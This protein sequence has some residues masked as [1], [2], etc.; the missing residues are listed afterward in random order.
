MKTLLFLSCTLSFYLGNAQNINFIDALLKGALIDSPEVS[1]S[2]GFVDLNG[3]IITNVDT[4]SDGEISISEAQNIE[5]IDFY[6][7]P[8]TDLEGLQFFTNVKKITSYNSFATTFNFPSLINLEELV[9][10]G[11]Y[12][13]QTLLSFNVS[14]NISL[15]IL[16]LNIGLASTVDLSNNI[17][18][19][20]LRIRDNDS[21]NTVINLD[22]LS[23]LRKLTYF[24]NLPTLDISDCNKLIEISIAYIT[25]AD[26]GFSSIDLTNQPLLINLYI[27]NTNISSLDL[28]ANLNLENVFVQGNLLQ[29]INFGNLLYVR[30]LYCDNNQL[31]ALDL[32]NFQNLDALTCG[33][34]NLTELKLKNFRIEQYISFEG[35]PNLAY[36]CCDAEQEVYIQNQA[37]LNENYDTVVDSDCSSNGILGIETIK[38]SKSKIAVFPN[39]TN[40]YFSFSNKEVIEKVAIYDLNGRSIKAFENL[41]EKLDV[42]FLENGIY[43]LKVTTSGELQT[44]KLIKE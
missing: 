16:E 25:A 22:N 2:T 20:E 40:D 32:N 6:Y 36:I 10:S 39:P 42:S 19:I 18:L 43:F 29:N 3:N 41:S 23:N 28:S 37:L 34:N 11:V 1:Y 13:Q 35:N 30:N 31:T 24:G 26:I 8:F 21:N 5:I 17:N 15:K 38:N 7:L 12:D 27:S 4:N 14:N 33:N 44:I 9:L